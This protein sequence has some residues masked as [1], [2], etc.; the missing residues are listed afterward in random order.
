M[1]KQ[2][3]R[4]ADTKRWILDCSRKLFLEHGYAGTSTQMILSESGLSKGAVYHHFDS[5]AEIFEQIFVETSLQAI[6]KAGTS[7]SAQGGSDI[8]RIKAASFAWLYQ[9]REDEVATILLKL[10]PEALGWS[11]ARELE[12]AQSLP[13]LKAGLDEFFE[14]LERQSG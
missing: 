14:R 1:V 6:T 9:I 3:Q 13:P 7:I 5:K 2:A 10:G 11:R 12:N 8:E 4:R